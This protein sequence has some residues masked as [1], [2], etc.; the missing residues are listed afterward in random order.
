MEASSRNIPTPKTKSPAANFQS[1]HQGIHPDQV[2]LLSRGI[3]ADKPTFSSFVFKLHLPTDTG[4]ERVVLSETHIGA[5]LDSGSPLAD[6]Y[7]TA[8]DLL[9]VESLDA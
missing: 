7:G 9:A 2:F 5:W 3:D 4:E 6:Q 8:G 1:P